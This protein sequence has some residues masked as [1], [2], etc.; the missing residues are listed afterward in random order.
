[1]M[2]ATS[3]RTFRLPDTTI[4]RIDALAKAQRP[5]KPANRTEVLIT[6]VDQAW[7]AAGKPKTPKKNPKNPSIGS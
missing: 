7:E 5:H 1:M 6:L 2:P 3:L 4:E